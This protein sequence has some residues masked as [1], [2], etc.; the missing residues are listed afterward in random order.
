MCELAS[1]PFSLPVPVADT[2]EGP[3][4]NWERYN[5]T[6]SF[7]TYLHTKA[8]LTFKEVVHFKLL[9]EDELDAKVYQYDGAVEFPKSSVLDK[10]I[11][12]GEIPQNESSEYKHIAIGF[13]EIGSNISIIFKSMSYVE[14]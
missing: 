13:N 5:L 3:V 4:I 2:E 11:E 7:T 6:I 10:L 1:K 8:K 14:S 9:S 12:V